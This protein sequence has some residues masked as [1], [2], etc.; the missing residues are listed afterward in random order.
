VTPVAAAFGLD[1]MTL[2]RQAVFRH[3]R[4]TAP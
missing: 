4:Y 3:E 1:N 2:A